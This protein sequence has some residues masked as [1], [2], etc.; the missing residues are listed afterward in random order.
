MKSLLWAIREVMRLSRERKAQMDEVRDKGVIAKLFN[1][2]YTYSIKYP[3]TN[4]PDKWFPDTVQSRRYAWMCPECNK[5]HAPSE[6]CGL[7]G[8]HCPACC[9]I[10]SGHR[11]YH[12][13]KVVK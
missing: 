1:D 3:A 8:L 2:R 4:T 7:T 5:V 6:Y 10:P 13:L 11:L 9:G 12:G